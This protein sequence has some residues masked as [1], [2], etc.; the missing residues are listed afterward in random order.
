MSVSIVTGS[1]DSPQVYRDLALTNTVVGVYGSMCELTGWNI[2]NNNSST[3]YVKFFEGTSGTI[4]LGTTVPVKVLQIPANTTIYLEHNKT[5]PQYYFKTAPSIVCVT[6]L[7]DTN[8]TAPSTAIYTEIF[9][10]KT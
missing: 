8:T 1:S 3:V 2:I 7:A 4:T 9:Y 6:G 10:T 5:R